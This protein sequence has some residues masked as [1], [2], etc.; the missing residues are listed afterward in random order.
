MK[1]PPITLLLCLAPLV[2]ACAQSSS[3]LPSASE[4]PNVN[5]PAELIETD[6]PLRL[7]RRTPTIVS[8]RQGTDT[9]PTRTPPP[10]LQVP[11]EELSEQ[12]P[13]LLVSSQSS[14]MAFNPAGSGQDALI[15]PGPISISISPSG[16]TIAYVTD[17]VPD[18]DALGLQLRLRDLPSGPDRRVTEL[19]NSS[20]LPSPD[21]DTMDSSFQSMRA[22]QMSSPRWSHG[23]DYLAFIGQQSGPSADLFVYDLAESTITRLT[24]GPSQAYDPSWSPDDDYIFHSGAWNFGTGAGF[25]NAGSWVV[26]RDGTRIIET[27]TGHGS[28]EILGWQNPR[29][30]LLGSWSQPCGLAYLSSFSID[31]EESTDIW[32]YYFEDI[33]FQ[34]DTGVL[35]LSVPPDFTDCGTDRQPTGLFIFDEVRAQPRSISDQEYWAIWTDP[36]NPGSFLLREPEG[37]A[38]LVLP[39]AI[40][41]LPNTLST[42]PSYSLHVRQWLWYGRWPDLSGIWVGDMSAALALIFDGPVIDAAWSPTGADIFFLSEEDHLL[43]KASPP[44]YQPRPVTTSTSFDDWS[45]LLW[46]IP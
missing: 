34:A 40:Q 17:A 39:D 15:S 42:W 22:I 25:S 13:W 38:R 21:A 16:R 24:D 28:D 12:G 43:Y 6:L 44:A 32:P 1:L 3:R 8:P 7:A 29:R 30:F 36:A 20:A 11:Q 19:Q 18:D 26:S 45:Y 14:L 23:G 35:L 31:G 33:L 10:T 2:G 41:D 37:W 5:R 46:A 9:F 4:T 27:T